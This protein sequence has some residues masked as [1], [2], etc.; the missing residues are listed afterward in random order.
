M[1]FD[2]DTIAPASPAA[3]EPPAASPAAAPPASPQAEATPAAGDN[4]FDAGAFGDGKP[5]EA[6]GEGEGTKTPEGEGDAPKA[7]DA[8]TGAPEEYADFTMPEG[9]TLDS[10]MVGQL[11]EVAKAFDLDQAKAQQLV[12]L[13]VQQ[14]QRFVEAQAQAVAAE[15]SA[16]LD[17]TR[18]DAEIGGDKLVAALADAKRGLD[19]YGSPALGEFL[20]ETKLN[21][22]P[23][24]IRFFAKIGKTVS[25]DNFVPAGRQA[26]GDPTNLAERLYPKKKGA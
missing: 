20:R 5:P 15:H 9:V 25:E 23:E 18:G 11:K 26:G 17:A 7:D 21:T 12:D 8:P 19:A 24:F 13:G 6:Q 3:V 22:H 2:A 14:A 10:E 16:W 4:T 1:P